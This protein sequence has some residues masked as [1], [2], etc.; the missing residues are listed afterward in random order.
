MGKGKKGKVENY[1]GKNRQVNRDKLGSFKNL[2]SLGSD[3]QDVVSPPPS[4]P[5]KKSAK[6]GAEIQKMKKLF[7][8][9]DRVL[10][11]RTAAKYKPMVR[12]YGESKKCIFQSLVEDYNCDYAD[13]VKSLQTGSQW[14]PSIVTD[15]HCH[16][17]EKAAF[18]IGWE[19]LIG[20]PHLLVGQVSHA[21]NVVSRREWKMRP[22]TGSLK[23]LEKFRTQLTKRRA[24]LDKKIL[25]PMLQRA[26]TRAYSN[27][28]AVTRNGDSP[29][30]ELTSAELADMT[31]YKKSFF[32]EVGRTSIA[33]A[34]FDGWFDTDYISNLLEELPAGK[35]TLKSQRAFSK[36]ARDCLK[37]HAEHFKKA[38]FY[39]ELSEWVFP[40]AF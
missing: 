4:K 6:V 25:I 1:S 16:T 18:H 5:A 19:Q 23:K 31:G 33:L 13:L 12:V 20:A 15:Q 40:S 30:E 28:K 32:M 14:I 9:A 24:S 22:F 7:N 10:R 11:S 39:E 34:L 17:F 2:L 3:L 26:G 21:Q 38:P 8:K 35:F 27:F 37:R 36:A 29:Y